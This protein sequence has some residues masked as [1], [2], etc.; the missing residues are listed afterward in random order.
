M[1]F[2]DHHHVHEAEQQVVKSRR[3]RQFF[4][5]QQFGGFGQQQFGQFGQQP[6]RMKQKADPAID[7]NTPFDNPMHFNDPRY[8]LMWYANRGG[9]DQTEHSTVSHDHVST[10]HIAG[11]YQLLH[12]SAAAGGL[13]SLQLNQHSHRCS[14][15]TRENRSDV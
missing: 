6:W 4:G 14:R 7:P 5:Q 9:I 12:Q 15:S 10:N 2:Q 11:W 1:T 3:R 13:A 8:P